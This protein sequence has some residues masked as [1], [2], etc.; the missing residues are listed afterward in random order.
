MSKEQSKVQETERNLQLK[1]A[2]AL[3]KIFP[4]LQVPAHLLKRDTD[5]GYTHYRIAA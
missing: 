2:Q 1:A 5:S 4:K 3:V